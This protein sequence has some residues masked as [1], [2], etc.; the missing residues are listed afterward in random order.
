[1]SSRV[2]M[3]VGCRAVRRRGIVRPRNPLAPTISTE[4]I[5]V[6]CVSE[7]MSS[8]NVGVPVQGN[9]GNWQRITKARQHRKFPGA[10]TRKMSPIGFMRNWGTDG[11]SHY[12]GS[13][14]HSS[15]SQGRIHRISFDQL[16]NVGMQYWLRYGDRYGN[17]RQGMICPP[18]G[19]HSPLLC[20]AQARTVLSAYCHQ[21]TSRIRSSVCVGA[22]V[23]ARWGIRSSL[24]MLLPQGVRSTYIFTLNFVITIFNQDYFR[25]LF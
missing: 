21:T 25:S 8:P 11:F 7:V 13:L 3:H 20:V 22:T 24:G 10:T 17:F 16:V 23:S 9:S 6:G 12:V 19:T 14:F 2:N 1:M 18:H 4:G 15:L 5:G